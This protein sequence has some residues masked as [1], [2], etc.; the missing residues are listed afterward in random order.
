[1]GMVRLREPRTAESVEHV[2]NLPS[3][4][5]GTGS[6]FTSEVDLAVVNQAHRWLQGRGREPLKL[7]DESL[8]IS[9]ARDLLGWEAPIRRHT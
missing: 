6:A 9:H 3:Q 2:E 1:M 8:C 4:C 7:P 5:G